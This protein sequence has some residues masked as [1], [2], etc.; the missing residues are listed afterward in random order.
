M[1]IEICI[2]AFD[3]RKGMELCTII[4]KPDKNGYVLIVSGHCNIEEA[5]NAFFKMQKKADTIL[6]FEE[7][8][9]GQKKRAQKKIA[10]TNRQDEILN[11]M[12][13]YFHSVKDGSA[14]QNDKKRLAQLEK[15][16]EREYIS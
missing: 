16:L 10:N 14:T 1:E 13:Y 7:L 15:E 2:K 9:E 12:D 3:T 11:E 4:R 8:S 6:T 5:K